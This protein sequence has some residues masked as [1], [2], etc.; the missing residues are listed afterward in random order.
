MA[1]TNTT[2]YLCAAALIDPNF[3]GQFQDKIL[4]DEYRAISLPA[5]VDLLAVARHIHYAARIGLIR[6]LVILILFWMGWQSAGQASGGGD[7]TSLLLGQ[8]LSTYFS[9][10]FL[11]SWLVVIFENWMIRYQII[12]KSLLKRNF[13]PAAV[14][15]SREVDSDIR[16]KLS[17]VINEDECNVVVYSGFSPFIGSGSDI[18]GWSFSLDTSKG[19]ESLGVNQ[20]PDPFAIDELYKSIESQLVNMQLQGFSIQDKIFVNGRDIRGDSRFLPDPFSRPRAHIDPNEMKEF[21]GG[22]SEV[23]RHYKCIRVIS[24]DGEVVLSIFLRFIK[25]SQTLFIEA[26]NFLLPPLK[27][28]YRTIDE[29][30]DRPSWRQLADLFLLAFFKALLLY[31]FAIILFIREILGPVAVQGRHE[32]D[33]R[34]IRENPMFDYGASFSIR[35]AASSGLYNHYFQK[36]DYEMYHKIIERKILDGIAQFLD[37]HGIDA[38]DLKARQNTILN[39]GIIITGGSMNSQNLTVG[40]RAKSIINAMSEAVT[41]AATPQGMKGKN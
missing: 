30:Q 36:L 29:I 35:E 9:F 39:S 14:S 13:N 10:F 34:L 40:D 18:G 32:Q 25:H 15:L 2:R 21:I 8:V 12:A 17:D 33:R 3:R 28:K 38:S 24:W 4:D 1:N 27:A 11:I 23:V 5:G 19:R 7:P 37:D 31:P 26:S 16:R 20:R 22:R 6:N 41:T